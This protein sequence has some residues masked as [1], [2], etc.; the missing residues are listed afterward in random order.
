MKTDIDATPAP[1]DRATRSFKR[2]LPTVGRILLGF[3]LV[4]FGLNAF[5]NFMP[6]PPPGTFAP[7]AEAFGQALR[8]TGYMMPLIGITQLLAGLLLLTNRW[9]PLALVLLAPLFVNIIAFHV[10]LEHTGLP[11]AAVFCALELALAW[12]SRRA[13]RD[14]LRPRPI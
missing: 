8:N 11:M 9:V 6:P 1:T 12:H 3:P 7:S 5:A 10:C 2:H 13:Y 4:V 14:L